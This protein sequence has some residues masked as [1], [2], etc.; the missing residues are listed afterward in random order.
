MIFNSGDNRLKH[1]ELLIQ[2]IN[3][4]GEISFSLTTPQKQLYTD[5]AEQIANLINGFALGGISFKQKYS[6]EQ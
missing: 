4:G 2:V 1:N 6:T 5:S 3:E